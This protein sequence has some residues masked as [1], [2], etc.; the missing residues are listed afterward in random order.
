LKKHCDN[1][2]ILD[3]GNIEDFGAG[4]M[5]LQMVLIPATTILN[6]F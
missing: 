6:A 2:A 5:A 4:V 1:V 3:R